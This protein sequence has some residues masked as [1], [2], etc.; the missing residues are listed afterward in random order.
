MTTQGPDRNSA[1]EARMN[2]ELYI[3]MEFGSRQD[4]LVGP[5]VAGVPACKRYIR[6]VT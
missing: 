5:Q 1:R 6:E 4:H 3:L 2:W